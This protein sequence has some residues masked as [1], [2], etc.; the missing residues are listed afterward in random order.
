MLF[1]LIILFS[2]LNIYSSCPNEWIEKGGFIWFYLEVIWL[3][4]LIIVPQ[5]IMLL[6]L[7][8]HVLWWTLNKSKIEK[9]DPLKNW[10]LIDFI[11]K[12]GLRFI[13]TCVKY[14]GIAI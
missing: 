6:K 12:R 8:F 14:V 10:K 5:F 3:N 2:I 7:C 13:T 11:A 4:C 1:Y 9:L